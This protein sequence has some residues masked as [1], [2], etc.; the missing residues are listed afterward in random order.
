MA[1]FLH[2]TSGSAGRKEEGSRKVAKFAKKDKGKEGKRKRF[3]VNGRGKEE[4]EWEM[5]KRKGEVGK[6]RTGKE[7]RAKGERA[8]TARCA[9]E[10]GAGTN[11]YLRIPEARSERPSKPRAARGGR[12][13][14]REARVSG[15]GS[16]GDAEPTADDGG[17][18]R[19]G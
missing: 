7:E 15:Q 18:V 14:W 1:A 12:R 2:P 10:A 9:P 11:R 5:V 19:H 16:V 8:R 13:D 4:K 17:W 3:G 6:G